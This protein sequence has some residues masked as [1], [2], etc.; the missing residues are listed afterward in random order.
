MR[1][2]SNDVLDGRV[3]AAGSGAEAPHSGIDVDFCFVAGMKLSERW[4]RGKPCI[5][6]MSG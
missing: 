6:V 2:W 5:S 4:R 1:A 3:R